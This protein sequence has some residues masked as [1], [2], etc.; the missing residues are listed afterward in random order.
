MLKR[1]TVCRA[2][3]IALAWPLA[4]QA[5]VQVSGYLRNR[6]SV[7]TGDGQVIGEP[8]TMLDRAGH[9]AGDLMM[10]ENTA[11]IFLNG[12]LG[13]VGSWHFEGNIVGDTE[14]VNHDW[15]WHKLYTQYDYFRELYLDSEV[16]GWNLRLGKQQV[17]WGTA[18]GIKLLDIINPTD[19][20]HLSQDPME[21]SR[22]D[23]WM[24]N[25]ERNMGSAGSV[26]FIVAQAKPNVI[27]G[28]NADG[29]RGQ[30]FKLQGVDAI[31]G[32]VNGFLNMTPA[33]GGVSQSFNLAAQGGAFTGGTANPAGLV[34]FAGLTVDGFA[35][36]YYTTTPTG[37]INQATSTTPGAIKGQYLLNNIAQNGLYAGDPNGNNWVTNLLPV[38]GMGFFDVRWDPANRTSAFETFPNATFATFNTFAAGG[39]VGGARSTYVKDYPSKGNPNFGFR[40]KNKTAGGLNFSLNY[41][42]D[43]DPNPVVNLS[44][45]DAAT[46]EKLTVQRAAG[47]A[48]A[49]PGIAPDIT[50]N[51]STSQVP[52][53]ASANPLANPTILLR[54]SAGQYYGA[55][56]PA[57]FAANANT[58][59]VELRFTETLN[60]IHNI[61]GS[62]DYAWDTAMLGPIVLRGELL[63]QKD[64]M[65]PVIDKRLLAIGDLSNGLVMQ[66]SDFFK[67]VLGAD[68]TVLKNMLVS[69]QFIQFRNLDF[70]EEGRTCT[71]QT[72]I[73]FDCSRYT[74]DFPVL[75]PTNGL[76]QAN[77][78]KE[79]YSLFFSKPFGSSQ[80]HRWNNITIYE[81]NGGWWNRFDAEYSL[82]DNLILSG[83]LNAYWGEKNTQFGQ[84]KEASNVQLGLKYLF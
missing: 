56:D 82:T 76:L 33:L 81:E 69:F 79:F 32:K 59:P 43:Y 19:F 70:V 28:L 22:I 26:Q 25:V 3:V 46:G 5:D 55:V 17:V 14:G 37:L 11:K 66:K 48:V 6:T 58:N 65:Q 71:T 30:P 15:K 54:N 12:D 35:S 24:A 45:H 1:R 39:P 47:V 53:D 13:R 74:G 27:P 77:K 38:S 68:I 42:Y 21:D 60:R 9:D 31:T 80:Q 41:L 72:G 57:T 75:N 78:N 8:R 64:V 29:D 4:A 34:P 83:A 61:G 44:W 52:N 50:S 40:Y 20:R 36:G 18:D 84:L 62:F 73:R 7:F 10:F 67:Y 23:V 51:L 49:G 2:I 16:A 63:Y